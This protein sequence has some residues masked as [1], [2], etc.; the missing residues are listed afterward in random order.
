MLKLSNINEKNNIESKKLKS[1]KINRTKKNSTNIKIQTDIIKNI[2]ALKNDI[3]K[4]YRLFR[5]NKFLEINKINITELSNSHN[6]LESILMKNIDILNYQHEIGK[7]FIL[8][9][10]NF[11]NISNELINSINNSKIK[12]DIYIKANIETI[13][14]KDLYNQRLQLHELAKTTLPKS[15]ALCISSLIVNEYK[16]KY[17]LDNNNLIICKTNAINSINLLRKQ[18]IIAND[19]C[20]TQI[21]RM[22]KRL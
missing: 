16:N 3:F 19:N 11:I 10:T 12:E 20:Q 4:I 7:K 13:K 15:K 6:N 17:D 8:Y 14:S 18:I 5:K 21:I 9:A 1:N 22:M 2:L